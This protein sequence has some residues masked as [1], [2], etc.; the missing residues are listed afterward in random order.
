[1]ARKP[2]I[3]AVSRTHD[4]HRL[5][6]LI[7]YV[8][9]SRVLDHFFFYIKASYPMQC[10]TAKALAWLTQIRTYIRVC[11]RIMKT[12]ARL[13]TGHGRAARQ[14]SAAIFKKKNVVG[15]KSDFISFEK[16]ILWEIAA[17]KLDSSPVGIESPYC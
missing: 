2:D 4:M 6:L 3:A 7:R 13:L 8:S 5:A 12:P 10:C 16:I 9:K 1:M 17:R 11:P 14:M 15:E